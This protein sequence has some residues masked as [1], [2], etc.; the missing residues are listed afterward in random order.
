MTKLLLPGDVYKKLGAMRLGSKSKLRGQHK[1][2]HRSSRF[3]SSMDF[4]DYRAYH[5]GDDVRQIDWNVFARSEKYYI[6]RFLDEQEMRV[7]VLL[8]GTKSMATPE[9]WQL[10]KQL[11]AALGHLVLL[12][13]DRLTCSVITDQEVIPFRKKGGVYKQLFAQTMLN[14]AEPSMKSSFA[15]GVNRYLT[16]GQTVLLLITDALEPIY[17]LEACIQRLPKF[18]GDVRMLQLVHEEELNPTYQGDMEFEDI[19][20]GAQVNVS[21]GQSVL[22]KYKEVQA[23]HQ[24]QLEQ[25][26]AKYGVALLQVPVEEGFQHVFFHRLK[27]ANWVQ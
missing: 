1:G 8:D 24:Q 5:V 16:K 4:S 9:K 2:S 25:L 6:K 13:D 10:A 22:T 20:T 18:A 14:V 17:E 15:Q 7:H 19:E 26:C 12:N 23:K 11:T 21:M 3:G 27:K